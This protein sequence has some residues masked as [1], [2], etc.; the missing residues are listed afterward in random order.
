M[1]RMTARQYQT[2]VKSIEQL[3][4]EKDLTREPISKTGQSL[5]QFVS[6]NQMEDFLVSKHGPNP[7][8]SLDACP[9]PLM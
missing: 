3:K 2:L 7:F 8:K 4:L 1:P 5:V 9:C 6:D